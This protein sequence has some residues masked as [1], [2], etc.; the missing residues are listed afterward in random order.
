MQGGGINNCTY[1][2]SKEAI[3]N[4]INIGASVIE[5]D[6]GLTSDG[7]PVLT[8][9][10]EPDGEIM[11]DSIPTAK[12]FLAT[13]IAN[14]Q[15]PLSLEDFINCFG[16]Y[17]GYFFLD[18][19]MGCEKKVVS[20]LEKNS[21]INMR[22]KIIFQ[23]H[24]INFLKELYS[25]KLFGYLHYNSDL[26]TLISLIPLLCKYEVHT[27]SVSDAEVKNGSLKNLCAAG[28]HPYVY[29]VNHSRRYKKVLSEG[30]SGVFTDRL[31]P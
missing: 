24:D 10:F 7:V 4:S 26:D 15:T 13:P 19:K 20:W 5:I 3:E 11:F 18:C 30:A 12:E 25:K 27:V 23:I 17:E 14:G 21:S 29:T 28:I 8:H 16:S 6:I 31:V 1:L 9:W 22:K 2:N